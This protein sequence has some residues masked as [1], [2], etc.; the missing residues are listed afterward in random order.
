MAG[1]EPRVCFT[2]ALQGDAAAVAL[3]LSESLRTLLGAEQVIA[4]RSGDGAGDAAGKARIESSEALLAVIAPGWEPAE[5][6][7]SSDVR[8]A[9][10]AHIPVIPVLTNRAQMPSRDALPD[11]LQPLLT[12]HPRCTIEIPAD[13]VWDVMVK[14]LSEWLRDI[15]RE[16]RKRATARENAS[17]KTHKLTSELQ[18]AEQTLAGARTALEAATHHLT[19]A[20][21]GV[22]VAQEELTHRQRGLDP[23]RTD[24]A[25]RVFLSYRSD[26]SGHALTLQTE[27]QE[28]LGSDRVLGSESASSGPDPGAAIEARVSRCDA[29]LAVVGPSWMG[30][31]GG[32]VT[33][34]DDDPARLEVEAALKHEIPVVPVLTPDAELGASEP[35]PA[36]LEPLR[37]ERQFPLSIAF[38]DT[39]L[40]SII[41][42]LKEVESGLKVRLGAMAAAAGRLKTAQD[43]A[44]KAKRD[45]ER[46]VAAVEKAERELAETHERLRQ[47]REEEARLND[48]RPDQNP[49]FL[50]GSGEVRASG[51]SVPSL[52]RPSIPPAGIAVG[53]AIV[54]LLIIIIA[55][56]H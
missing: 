42:R 23:A 6:A 20:D 39:A 50:R 5:D 30:P 40:E 7:F 22:V 47:A 43:G 54:L 25:V 28:R 49:V 9:L 36:S 12:R 35:L 38:W 14:H 21:H 56:A 41:A 13:P 46:S 37:N 33:A 15:S 44:R 53:V 8:I 4:A 2:A 31:S 18:Q 51:G 17:K 19:E 3:R 11:S 16:N 10:E 29:L 24:P 45:Q 52:P 32:A 1:P 34:P 26:T 27:L 48:E 55:V